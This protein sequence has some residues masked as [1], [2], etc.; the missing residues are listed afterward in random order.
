MEQQCGQ[1]GGI[2]EVQDLEVRQHGRY[3]MQWAP[4]RACQGTGK[5]KAP[6]PTAPVPATMWVRLSCGDG[7]QGPRVYDWAY[8]PLR[9]AV[10]EGWVHALLS[11]RHPDR[12]ADVAWYLIYAPGETSLDG[13]VRAAGT[14]WTI[15]EVFKLA[16]GQ[17][18]LDQYEVRS[19]QGWHRHITLALI[20]LAALATAAKRGSPL[21]PPY[22]IHDPRTAAAARS[23]RLARHPCSG[24]GLRLVT[25]APPPPARGPG[26]PPPSPPL[27]T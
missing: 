18:G 12:P 21:R 6:E 11:R 25:L 17:V 16:K 2:G 14:R 7:A 23:P 24:P 26:V 8:Q 4:C 5:V 19:W 3:Q 9:P 13:I 20:A 1:C 22:P 15:E 10:R 27:E